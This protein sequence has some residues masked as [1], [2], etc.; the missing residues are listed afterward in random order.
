MQ[1]IRKLIRNRSHSGRN[2]KIRGLSTAELI[3]IIII[4]GILGALGG[5][6]IGSLVSTANKNAMAQNVNS[7]N[8]V[9]ASMLSGGVAVHSADGTTI[10]TINGSAVAN[11]GA[12]LTL[13]NAGVIDA[14]TNVTYAM[15]PPISQNAISN[16][17]TGPTYTY[18]ITAPAGGGAVTGVTWTY[19]AALAP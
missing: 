12:I 6:Y 19:N 5:T 8:T 14:A 1:L 18:T 17:G 16:G 11:T 15:T 9:S 10:D 4:V 2:H 7:L 13:L 3:G